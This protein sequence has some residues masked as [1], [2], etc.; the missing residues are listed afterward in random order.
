MK[1]GG[2]MESLVAVNLEQQKAVIHNFLQSKHLH[3]QQQRQRWQQ[4]RESTRTAFETGHSRDF[5]VCSHYTCSQ[6]I[7][8]LNS[9]YFCWSKM[10]IT[11]G[12]ESTK[13]L[14]TTRKKLQIAWQSVVPHLIRRTAPLTPS[15][16]QRGL[17]VILS[18]LKSTPLKLTI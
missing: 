11:T 6:K 8:I 10:L 7:G 12:V 5:L 9:R 17:V 15:L 1:K 3:I 4:W 2:R 14:N 16:S 18:K 13:A